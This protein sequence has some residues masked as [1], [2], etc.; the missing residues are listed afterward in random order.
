MAFDADQ[1]IY[2]AAWRAMPDCSLCRRR[3]ILQALRVKLSPKHPAF[4]NA[5]AQLAMLDGLEK[6]QSEF[7]FSDEPK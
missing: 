6:L 1:I 3:Q 7:P 5:G 4:N 2:D